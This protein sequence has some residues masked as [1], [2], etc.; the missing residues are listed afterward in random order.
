MALISQVKTTTAQD[1]LD[2]VDLNYCR[3]APAKASNA[4]NTF[5]SANLFVPIVFNKERGNAIT[6]GANANSFHVERPEKK[7]LEFYNLTLPVGI[8][9][10]FSEKRTLDFT[11]LNRLNSD[12]SS[13]V[14]NDYQFGFISNLSIKK[15]DSLTYKVGLYYNAELS[16]PLF[17]PLFG[18]NWKVN[19]KLQVYG[20][21]P[22]DATVQYR[23]N[24]RIGFGASFRGEIASYK[25]HNEDRDTYVQRA[26]NEIGL[27][28][29]VYLTNSVVFQLK[30]GYL[31][32]TQYKEYEMDDKIDWAL[33]L[34]RFGDNRNELSTIKS[35]GAFAKASLIYRFDLSNL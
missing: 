35:D 15:H 30:G 23:V 14:W 5:Q 21:L 8:H 3:T 32:G 9:Y 26:R 20:S 24:K 29:D 27:F 25:L 19:D 7:D 34:F 16:G 6:F 33:S 28:A 22:R 10:I 18:V 11:V 2:I 4:A 31:L 1:F 12:F 13:D 17:V